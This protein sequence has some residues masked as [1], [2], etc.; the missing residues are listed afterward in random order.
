MPSPLHPSR[1]CPPF[2]Q[3]LVSR[4]FRP[5]C[6]RP[7]EWDAI[8]CRLLPLPIFQRRTIDSPSAASTRPSDLPRH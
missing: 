1:F 2:Q 7:G 6:I 8:I 4:D 5:G 3:S